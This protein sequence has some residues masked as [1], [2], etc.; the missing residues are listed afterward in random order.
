MPAITLRIKH[1]TLLL[2]VLVGSSSMC[3]YWSRYNDAVYSSLAHSSGLKPKVLTDL[4]PSW[5]GTRELLLH[6]RDPYSTEVNRELQI[7]YYGKELDP[8]RPEERLNQQRFAYPLY[9]T[10]FIAPLAW[11]QF[12]TARIVFWWILAVCAVLNVL[13]WL[14]FLRLRLSLPAMAA[15]FALVLTS[16]PVMQNLSLLQP[17]LLP[18]CFLAGAAVAVVSGRLFLAGALLAGATVKP[19]ICL[20]PLAWFALWLCSDWK[21]RRS[22]FWGFTVTLVTLVLASAWLL[23]DWVVRYPSVLRA[24]AGYARATSFLATLLPLPPLHWLITILTLATVAGF[25]WRARRQPAGSAAF[26]IALS[27][28]LTLTDLIVPAVVQ[29]LNHVLLLPAVLLAIRYWRELRQGR[30]V[31]RAAAS[32]FCLC[33]VLPWLLAVVAISKPLTPGSDW[34]LKMWSVPLAASMALPF[35]AFGVLIL[36]GQVEGLER[37]GPPSR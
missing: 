9:F 10:F 12:Q 14:R 18:A 19:Q 3:L 8:S 37:R 2:L 34:L 6:H 5:Y 11:I 33:A 22:L 24:Y 35:A 1:L 36:V 4:Y 13:L 29:P 28:V 16:I 20:L 30:V 21:R 23:P 31:T 26:A 27:F 32:V 17:F 15:L 7:A 25:C